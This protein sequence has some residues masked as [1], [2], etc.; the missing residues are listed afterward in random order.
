M[1]PMYLTLTDNTLTFEDLV[2]VGQDAEALKFTLVDRFT[3]QPIDRP[4][5]VAATDTRH[6][7]VV[8]SSVVMHSDGESTFQALFDWWN[9]C[10]IHEIAIEWYHID[11]AK[12]DIRVK[13][14]PKHVVNYALKVEK[15]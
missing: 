8:V 2:N 3:R 9:K 12:V 10:E 15:A 4:M 7:G 14:N 6:E 11:S 5:V 1:K 13:G